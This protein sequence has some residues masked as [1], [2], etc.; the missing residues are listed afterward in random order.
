M[1]LDNIK[2]LCKK[3]GINISTLE[4]EAR[5]GNGTIRGWDKSS[6]SVEN[7]QKVAN[8]FNVP[9]TELLEEDATEEVQ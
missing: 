1:I 3:Q 9:I 8:Y 4:K 2:R 7:L 6:P 5:L